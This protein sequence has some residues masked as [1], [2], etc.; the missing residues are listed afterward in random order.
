MIILVTF[1]LCVLAMLG[2]YS[3]RMSSNALERSYGK[4]MVS[5]ANVMHDTLLSILSSKI[6]SIQNLETRPVITGHVYNSNLK[7][8]EMSDTDNFILRNDRIWK[9]YIIRNEQIETP[10]NLHN[11]SK[12]QTILEDPKASFREETVPS[13]IQKVLEN[14]VVS[15]FKE[16]FFDFY[17]TRSGRTVFLKLSMTNAF[18]VNIAST[19]LTKR[20]YEGGELWWQKAFENGAYI[21]EIQ[22]DEYLGIYGLTIAVRLNDQDNNFLGVVKVVL[23]STWIMREV[24]ALTELNEYSDVRLITLDGELVYSNKPFKFFEN[25]SDQAFLKKS[26]EKSGYFIVKEGGIDKLY[27]CSHPDSYN[28]NN[29]LRQFFTKP[30][31]WSLYIGNHVD[32]VMMPMFLLQKRM[33]KVYLFVILLSLIIAFYISKIYTALI[34]LLRDAAVAVANGDFNQCVETNVKDELGD[35]T[36]SF[37]IMTS[38]LKTNYE[39]LEQEIHF[40]K[41]AQQEAESAREKSE[42]A[43]QEAESANR[44]KSDFLANMSHE[45]RTPLNAIIGFSQLMERDKD[46]TDSQRE[47]TNIIMRS[48][49]HLLN[50]INDI[51]AISKIEAGKVEILYEDFDFFQMIQDIEAMVQPRIHKAGLEFI[52]DIDPAIPRYIKSD[53]QKLRQVLINLLVNAVK[54][55]KSGFVSLRIRCQTC[56]KVDGIPRNGVILFEVEDSGV[57]IS[58]EDIKKLFQKFMRTRTSMTT[59]EGTG[60]GLSISQEYVHLM[61]G[62]ITVKSTVDEGSLFSFFIDVEIADI[63]LEQ[64]KKLSYQK[65]VALEPGQPSTR[66]LIVEDNALNQMLLSR[67][68]ESVGFEVRIAVDGLEGVKIF[69]SWN[70]HLIWMDMRMPVMDGYEACR[71]IRQIEQNRMDYDKRIVEQHSNM[72]HNHIYEKRGIAQTSVKKTTIIALTASAFEEQK[73]LVLLAGCDDFIRKPFMENEIFDAIAKHIGVKYIYDSLERETDDNDILASPDDVIPYSS[74]SIMR[75]SSNESIADLPEQFVV[76]MQK[77]LIDL[78]LDNIEQLVN[79]IAAKY[80]DTARH[81]SKLASG[82]KYKEIMEVLDINNG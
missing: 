70:P 81:I 51:L 31:G 59:S 78:D 17:E 13:I 54:F 67:L 45:L 74:N 8:S 50:L 24:Q 60:L 80:P 15:I 6:E 72:D 55:T 4:N 25:I 3:I 29:N 75:S 44:A 73:N 19:D 27:A 68:L 77:A 34:I 33:V 46:V 69:E 56:H 58:Q 20:Y 14:E 52:T 38:N 71:R 48:G 40:R 21:S 12:T 66:I 5:M 64:M 53:E 62:E 35:L 32:N 82:F 16:I 7:F 30:A 43:R 22:Y 61:G 23:S 63:I 18:G 65:V 76:N 36:H 42:T 57:G 11:N 1:W 26:T 41:A 9:D 28:Q 49:I 47:T 37:N 10:Q 39:A 2:F 79:G